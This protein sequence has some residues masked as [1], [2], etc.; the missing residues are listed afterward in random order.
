[1]MMVMVGLLSLSRLGWSEYRHACEEVYSFAPNIEFYTITNEPPL[2]S[3]MDGFNVGV[4]LS[5]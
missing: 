5:L 1:M 4:L 2:H 3:I